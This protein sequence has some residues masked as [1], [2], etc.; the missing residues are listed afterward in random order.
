MFF[1]K[2]EKYVQLFKQDFML[3]F[4]LVGQTEKTANR[5]ENIKKRNIPENQAISIFVFNPGAEIIF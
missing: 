3:F 5:L 1:A 4:L 2:F